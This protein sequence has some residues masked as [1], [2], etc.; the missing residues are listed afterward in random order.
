MELGTSSKKPTA[1]VVRV[2]T[3]ITVTHLFESVGQI[4]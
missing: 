2:V 1:S 3:D 4:K